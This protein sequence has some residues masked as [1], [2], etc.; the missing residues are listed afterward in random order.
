[1]EE[2]LVLGDTPICNFSTIGCDVHSDNVVCCSLQ[3]QKDGSWVQ[4]SQT[5]ATDYRSLND[6]SEWC[7]KFNSTCILMESTGSYWMSSFDVLNEARLPITIVNPAHVKGIAGRKTDHADSHW[8][9]TM[10][11][12]N[13]YKPSY[14]PPREYRHLRAV[15][16][17]VTKQ[18]GIVQSCK[19]R[20]TKLFVT[21]GYRLNVFSDEFGKTAMLAKNAIIEGKTPEEVLAVVKQSI[22]GKKLK[23]TNDE[24]LA[25]FYGCMTPQLKYAIES[26][27][28]MYDF[29]NQEVK[30]G[31]KYVISEVRRLDED[32]FQLLQTIP[33]IDEW[34]S[35]VIIVEIGGVSNFLNAFNNGDSFSA[36]LGLCPGNNNSNSKR[37][38]KKGRHGD[39]Y[40]RNAL[41]ESAQ[42]AVRTK[43]TT[44]QSKFRSL[45][46]RLGY[47]R[48]IVAIA[49]KIAK[50]VYYVTSR[51]VAFRDPHIDY[52]SLTCQRNKARWIKQLLRCND[53]EI[54]V[55]NKKTGELIDSQSF[56]ESQRVERAVALQDAVA[57]QA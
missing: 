54:T 47:K 29:A 28:R 56:Q 24:L 16:R 52:Q 20:E 50:M 48:S 25:A 26:N 21:G 36:W 10:A 33:G 55:R 27:R 12:N 43:G 31:K 40:L 14:V 46:V 51:Q 30:A 5:F 34:S 38:G 22:G 3:R 35:A 13:S 19:N 6:F 2:A 9:A 42:A 7:K 23:A 44:F 49:H 4:T 45:T 8:L 39:P 18:L 57:R 37:T 11:L 53:L 1:M 41:C 32:S 17:N 15:E